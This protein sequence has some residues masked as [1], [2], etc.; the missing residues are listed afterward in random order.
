MIL[1]T[2]GLTKRYSS[3]A[4]IS[5]VTFAIPEGEIAG[6]VGLNGAGKS[7]TINLML[8][9]LRPTSGEVKLFGEPV[10]PSNA[11]RSHRRI[12]FA[13]G[14][15]SLF[16][17]F[18]GEQY[19]RFLSRTYKLRD[20]TRLTE[21]STLFEPQLNK[22]IGQL[23]RGNKQKIALIGAFMANP[24]LVILD[25]PSSG[26]D[27]LMQQT[28]LQLVRSEGERGT[29]IFMSS[30]YLGE[31]TD[32][33]SRILFMRQGRLVE[34]MPAAQLMRLQGKAVMVK[35]AHKLAPP[36]EAR[37]VR[38]EASGTHHVLTFLY[39]GSPRQLQHWLASVPSVTD[40]SV[41]DHNP[42]AL[43]HELYT[44]TPSGGTHV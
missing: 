5:D 9:F 43:L 3:F 18:T 15:M 36:A 22:K 1:E 2:N 42:E 31:V 25:E 8:G 13:S 12:G 26:L 24:D 19:F 21:L 20:E 16:T 14:D 30:H 23:S 40:F 34:D 44:G 29:T 27:P 35:S 17:N 4:A 32:V 28:F 41:S 6:F 7:T 37:D 33:C 10:S 39:G 11:H 38:H